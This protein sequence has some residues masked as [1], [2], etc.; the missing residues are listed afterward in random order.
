[1]LYSIDLPNA[2]YRARNSLVSDSLEGMEPGWLVSQDL[3]G[4]WKLIVGRSADKLV[5][6]L[7][8]LG[9]INVF[10]HDSEHTYENMTFEYLATWPFIK[11][12]GTLISDDVNW[13]GA[14]EDFA[15]RVA[16]NPRVVGNLGVLRKVR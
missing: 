5:P 7:R 2:E 16:A 3:R 4:R 11:P 6:L 14:F 1:M 12:G 9:A 13:N 8:D 10:I 15:D